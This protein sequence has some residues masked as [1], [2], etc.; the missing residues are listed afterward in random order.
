MIILGTCRV[1]FALFKGAILDCRT[2]RAN[3]SPQPMG[4]AFLMSTGLVCSCR[5]PKCEV[6]ATART[7][8]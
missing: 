5:G 7:G 3:V 1:G 2:K 4:A 6:L 8:R